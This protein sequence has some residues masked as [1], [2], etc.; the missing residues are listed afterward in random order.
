MEFGGETRSRGGG[1]LQLEWKVNELIKNN[2]EKI[3]NAS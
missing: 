3:M 1:K 2:T